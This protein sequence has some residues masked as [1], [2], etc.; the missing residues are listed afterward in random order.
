VFF[1]LSHGLFGEANAGLIHGCKQANDRRVALP[2][3]S[4]GKMNNR[5]DGIKEIPIPV[6]LSGCPAA[7]NGIICAVIGRIL[8]QIDGELIGLG[9]LHEPCHKLSA[10]A[11]ILR[12]IIQIDHESMD[13][14]KAFSPA[15]PP[16]LQHIDQTIAGDFG[17]DTSQKQFI[18]LGNQNAYWSD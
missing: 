11:L 8:G 16:Q 5:V 10:I 2:G 17:G 6:V 7:F 18:A 9:K 4:L 14:L 1:Y 15:L 3:H 12:S 13:L